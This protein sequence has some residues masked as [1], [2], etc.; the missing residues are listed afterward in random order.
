VASPECN[1]ESMGGRFGAHRPE[2]PWQ[3]AFDE[4]LATEL[5]EEVW[6]EEPDDAPATP[7]LLREQ[8]D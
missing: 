4:Q 2:C 6:V 8:G 3:V 5:R 7:D 1:C